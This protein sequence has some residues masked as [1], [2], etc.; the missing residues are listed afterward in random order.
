M[1]VEEVQQSLNA[2]GFECGPPDGIWGA[3]SKAACTAF[4]RS[5]GLTADG[6]P[7][8]NTQ[9][10]LKRSLREQG[11]GQPQ[12]RAPSVVPSG[13]VCWDQFVPY[14]E[15][16]APARYNLTEPQIPQ[17]PPGVNFLSRI[18]GTDRTNCSTFTAYLLGC[19][20]GVEM[21]KD[22]W[23]RWQ[24]AK[25]LDANYEG[26]GPGVCVD[27]GL[28]EWASGLP[29]DGVY[30]MQTFT[31]WPAG[32]SWLVLDYDPSTDKALTLEANSKGGID[33]VGF[34]DAGSF[35]NVDQL[36]SWTEQVSMTWTKRMS[37][38]S[39]SFMCKLNIDH[40]TVRAWLRTMGR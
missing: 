24:I 1:T 14:L 2:L 18:L 27:L 9:R 4:Q 40:N 5:I 31:K 3:N 32:H 28:G 35:R 12:E 30:L 6:I 22:D 11:G 8:P 17:Q 37:W 21:S 15:A 19:G 10:A 29:R 36:G 13:S 34:W 39:D 23:L 26:Y 7:G 16:I 25:G 20:F 33:G 38:Y